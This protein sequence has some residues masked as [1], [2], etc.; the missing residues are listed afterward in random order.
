M[1]THYRKTY[2]EEFVEELYKNHHISKPEHISIENLASRLEINIQY[3]PT[4]S[5]AYESQNGTYCM[6]INNRIIPM[7]QRIDFLHELSHLLL[8]A[9]NQLVLPKQF[10]KAQ[11]E[12]ADNFAQY[13]SMPS[14][15]FAELQVPPNV[16]EAINY[17]SSYFGVPPEMAKKRFDQ[18][19]RRKFEG[20]LFEGVSDPATLKGGMQIQDMP[21]KLTKIFAYYDPHSTYDGPD[22]LIVC[23]DQKT[24]TTCFELVIPRDERFQQ[25]ELET[26][27]EMNLEMATR[28]D[29]ICFDGEITLQVHQ[30]VR[31][32]GFTKQNFVLQMRDV[33]QLIEEDRSSLRKFY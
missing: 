9:G 31:K 30:L 16:D 1:L 27:E 24:L 21:N 18:I 26:L 14:F 4:K 13:A 5:R 29:I 3:Y 15:M 19:M 20:V 17:I 23:F 22:Q 10:I 7:K 6:L 28:G 2:L 33:E 25:I 12:S 11:E 32:H 8:H